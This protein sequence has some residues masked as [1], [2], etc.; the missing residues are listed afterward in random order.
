MSLTRREFM[1]SL[2]I[3]TTSLM[4]PGLPASAR[5]RLNIILCMTD[6]QGFGD[7]GFHGNP[8]IRTPVLDRLAAG[9]VR[10]NTPGASV[11]TTS[12]SAP[13]APPPARAS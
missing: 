11:S 7:L 13:S 9:S 2:G 4:L 5:S 3:G 6:D 10:F 1:H 8:L 12:M